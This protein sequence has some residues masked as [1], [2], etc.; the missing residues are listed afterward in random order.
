M[1][2]DR[3]FG[4]FCVCIWGNACKSGITPVKTGCANAVRSL[5]FSLQ[6]PVE[7]VEVQG[8]SIVGPPRYL[9]WYVRDSVNSHYLVTDWSMILLKQQY[10]CIVEELVYSSVLKLVLSKW[11]ILSC[12]FGLRVLVAELV[13]SHVWIDIMQQYKCGRPTFIIGHLLPSMISPGAP[14]RLEARVLQW[15]N[16]QR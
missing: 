3:G 8:G 6:W 16:M 1:R 4:V 13:S 2:H 14:Y 11:I 5:C 7:K 10:S 12:Y 15:T 9:P